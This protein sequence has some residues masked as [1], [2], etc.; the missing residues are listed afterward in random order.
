[1]DSTWIRHTPRDAKLQTSA[2]SSTF[3]VAAVVAPIVC[4]LVVLMLAVAI[5]FFVVGY[6]RH[7]HA[8]QKGPLAL[9]FT[10][11]ERS[12]TL[13]EMCGAQRDHPRPHR[14]APSLRSQD[15]R[16]C[17]SLTDATRLSLAIRTRLNECSDVPVSISRV[18]RE[19]NAVRNSEV[20]ST[21]FQDDEDMAGSEKNNNNNTNVAT[22]AGA[23]VDKAV[24]VVAPNAKI[25]DRS[26]A[27][28]SS[29]DQDGIYLGAAFDA[30]DARRMSPLVAAQ[31]QQQQQQ[32]A[33][34]GG[35]GDESLWRG[36]RVRIALHWCREVDVKRDP[37]SHRYDYFG[38][39]VNVVARVEFYAQSGQVLVEGT[40][41][42]TLERDEDGCYHTLIEPSCVVRRIAKAVV[43][44]GVQDKVGLWCLVPRALAGRQFR[45]DPR[46]EDDDDENGCGD[47][48]HNTSAHRSSYSSQ[49]KKYTSSNANK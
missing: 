28:D 1:M 24:V 37:S 4:V 15:K 27:H 10:D 31:Q 34:G 2:D 45:R 12:T 44:K 8:P 11:I 19:L 26:A 48:A 49:F 14:R 9:V 32:L 36:L 22:S 17:K 5:G 20:D 13:W 42:T 23:A 29:E 40:T 41:M 30:V 47:D 43:L 33:K 25:G 39:D 6:L 3:P 46:L 38:H 21:T 16:P 35:E 7:R 18:Y